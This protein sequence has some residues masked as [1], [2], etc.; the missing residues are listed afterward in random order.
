[1]KK[2]LLKYRFLLLLIPLGL[3]VRYIDIK[4]YDGFLSNNSVSEHYSY[5]GILLAVLI[6]LI[7]SI[8]YFDKKS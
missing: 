6:I 5:L 1:M 7:F 8:I 2:N 3:F 4:V